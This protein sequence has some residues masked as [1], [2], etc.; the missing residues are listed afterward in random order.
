MAR[1]R[2]HGVTRQISAG[3]GRPGNARSGRR[4]VARQGG[5]GVFGLGVPAHCGQRVDR[6][7]SG[8]LASVAIGW[9]GEDD[10][11]GTAGL[12]TVA[13]SGPAGPAWN[14]FDGASIRQGR[15]GDEGKDAFGSAGNAR[16]HLARRANAGIDRIDRMGTTRSRRQRATLIGGP[17]WYGVERLVLIRL[18]LAGTAWR[19]FVDQGTA[20]MERQQGMMRNGRQA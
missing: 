13:R 8:R 10:A 6:H 20:G 3:P 7:R 14:G 11:G 12:A 19:G 16:R 9:C 5:L 1:I 17:G 18:D 15:Q 4:R 2:R